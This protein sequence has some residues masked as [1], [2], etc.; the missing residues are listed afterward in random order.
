MAEFVSEKVRILVTVGAV[1]S[2]GNKY[3]VVRD[4]PS[5]M[6]ADVTAPRSKPPVAFAPDRIPIVREMVDVDDGNAGCARAPGLIA[7]LHESHRRLPIVR[8]N[9]EV[10]VCVWPVDD[11]EGPDLQTSFHRIGGPK[12]DRHHVVRSV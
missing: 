2:V 6:L 3:E 10:A 11:R 4:R 5:G 12:G 8:I 7:R 9:V 1:L